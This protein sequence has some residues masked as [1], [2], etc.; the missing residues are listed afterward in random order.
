MKKLLIII[1]IKEIIIILN[2]DIVE[3]LIEEIEIIIILN[4]RL[5]K[6]ME[7]NNKILKII[8][9]IELKINYF[10]FDYLSN[11]KK[12]IKIHI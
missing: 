6:V 5:F 12:L 10:T 1:L 3:L 9:Q 4:L 11:F 7:Y 2:M 8:K